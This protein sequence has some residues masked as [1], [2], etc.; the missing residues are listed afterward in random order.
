V[1]LAEWAGEAAGHTVLSV[2]Y[3]MEYGGFEG[4][5][6]DLFVRPSARRHGVARALLEALVADCKQRGVKGLAVEVSRGN[7][8]AQNLYASFGLRGWTDDR[9][10]LVTELS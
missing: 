8:A 4:Y 3:A 7:H 5:I 9:E 1:W 10:V 6:D 2:R